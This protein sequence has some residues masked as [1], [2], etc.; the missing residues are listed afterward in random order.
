MSHAI[1]RLLSAIFFAPLFACSVLLTIR[2]LEKNIAN[3]R[4]FYVSFNSSKAGNPH[5]ASNNVLLGRKGL[6]SSAYS[7]PA[8]QVEVEQGNLVRKLRDLL[9]PLSYSVAFE[10]LDCFP[11]YVQEKI[12]PFAIILSQCPNLL[13]SEGGG[14][15]RRQ[16]SCY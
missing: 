2:G 5:S 7:E 3:L 13:F 6:E 8:H 11:H 14:V 15:G 1:K 16:A 12:A 10:Q 4:T 9:R